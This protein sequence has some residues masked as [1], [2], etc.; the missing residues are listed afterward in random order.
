MIEERGFPNF[1]EQ[2]IFNF[3]WSHSQDQK[4]NPS[5]RFSASV[6]LG[7]SQYFRQSVNQANTGNFLNNTLSSSVS[8]S[9]SFEGDLGMNL[10]VSA[11]H[12]QNTNTQEINMTCQLY[13][14][15]SI[16]F[17]LLNQNL[18]L[19]KV[20]LEN[21]NFQ[22]N[23]RGEN[24]IRTT[25]SLFLKS[26]MFNDAN[27]GLKHSIPI[28]TNFKVLEY[29]SVSTSVNYDENWVFKTFDPILMSKLRK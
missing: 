18:K 6:N 29:F 26:E 10:N 16:G 23:L 25:D 14:L 13:N 21:I 12:N 9:K 7:S 20:R 1:S 15:V 24:R 28:T 3:R 22:Y 2:Q 5:S 11:T 27:S 4:A 17:I 8:Y 19:K